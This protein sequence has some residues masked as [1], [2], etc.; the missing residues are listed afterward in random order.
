M[1]VLLSQGTVLDGRY[2]ILHPLGQG[3]FG[4]TYLAENI[5]LG[6]KIA[7]KELFW[8]DHCSRNET[9]SCVVLRDPKETSSFAAQ[10]E[11]FL[12]EARALRDYSDLPGIVRILDYFE[13]NATAYIVMEYIEGE[14]LASRV[15]KEGP[16]DEQSALKAMFPLAKSL[17]AIHGSGLI[18][19]D[20]SPEN[21]LLLPDGSMKLIDFGASGSISREGKYTAIA[22]DHYAP[23]E[24]YNRNG[25]QGPWTDVYAFCATLYFC[26]TGTA[27][28]SAVQRLFLDELPAPSSL[29]KNL[30]PEAEALILHGLEMEQ[31]KRFQT[32]EALAQSMQLLLKEEPVPSKRRLWPGLLAGLLLAVLLIGGWGYVQWKS[33]N[34]FYGKETLRFLVTPDD[35]LSAKEYAAY[36]QKLEA[37]LSD[38]AGADNYLL[39]EDGAS[40]EVT[41]PASLFGDSPADPILRDLLFTE[42]DPTEDAISVETETLVNWEDPATSLIAGEHQVSPS[43]FSEPTVQ[44]LYACSAPLTKGQRASL[45]TDFKVRLDALDTP[46]AFGLERGTSDQFVIRI[47]PSHI[48]DA[49]LETLGS[50]FLYLKGSLTSSPNIMCSYSESRGKSPLS[51]ETTADGQK[52][53]CFSASSDYS[54][55]ELREL[56]ETLLR[57]DESH[58][59]LASSDGYAFLEGKLDSVPTDGQFRLDHMR[60]VDGSGNEA[61]TDFMF[62]YVDALMNRSNLPQSCYL[63][64]KQLI[65][66]K[67]DTLLGKMDPSLYGLKIG[68]TPGEA[69]LHEEIKQLQ[70]DTGLRIMQSTSG[71]HRYFIFADLPLNSDF[72]KRA[73]SLYE[74]LVSQYGFSK[75]RAASWIYLILTNESTNGPCRFLIYPSYDFETKEIHTHLSFYIS[76]GEAYRPYIDALRD[77]WSKLDAE[78][79]GCTKETWQD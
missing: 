18:H 48:G 59:Y 78:Q 79:Y 49:V 25:Q 44:L 60:F 69:A 20:I 9:S 22:K 57:Y 12:R 65:D 19:R 8:R 30:S 52:A 3:G 46:Y 2:R 63:K 29:A 68:K 33:K 54:I 64:T 37:R 21:I 45:I 74:S 31:E 14:T 75:P 11:R 77:G 24:Q 56:A 62:D 38:F 76:R 17:A 28:D 66:S 23:P 6:M 71:T 35:A 73:L 36:Q 34:R 67:G 50:N 40:L 15:E 47:P 51:L 7:I 16:L 55:R 53:I 39:H 41:L 43:S 61:E 10:R 4:I 1:E 13:A 58:L 5:R 27:P 72:P 26:V 32:M 42:E 70:K